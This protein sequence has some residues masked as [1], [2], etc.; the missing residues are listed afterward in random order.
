MR[1]HYV[2]EGKE[3]TPLNTVFPIIIH[4]PVLNM[5]LSLPPFLEY[6]TAEKAC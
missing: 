2:E 4:H 6:T 5:P 1:K 3:K